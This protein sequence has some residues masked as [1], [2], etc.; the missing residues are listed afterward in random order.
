LEWR[1]EVAGALIVSRLE[2]G[3]ASEISK[4]LL[5]NKLWDWKLCSFVVILIRN[6]LNNFMKQFDK[7]INAV[8]E[9]LGQQGM[10][11]ITNQSGNKPVQQQ[12]GQV[13]P[14]QATPQAAPG[15]VPA[16][17]QAGAPTPTNN[18]TTMPSSIAKPM[19]GGATPLNGNRQV[20]PINP[21]ANG[22]AAQPQQQQGAVGGDPDDPDEAEF[23]NILNMHQSDPNG[24]TNGLNQLRSNGPKFQK[25]T[26]YVAGMMQPQA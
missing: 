25:F 5:I 15:Q 3:N 21:P 8:M 16:Q 18:S 6:R 26:N 22:V 1:G 14:G 24:F 2:G 4:N 7:F 23:N 13:Q 10:G 11:G 20:T 12:Q 19:S 17:P 9:G